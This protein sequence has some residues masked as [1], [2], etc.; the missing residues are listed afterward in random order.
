MKVIFCKPELTMQNNSNADDF[1][2]SCSEILNMYVTDKLYI[3]STFQVDQL[4]A[5][6]ADANDIFVFFNV[7]NGKYQDKFLRLIKKYHSAQSRIWAIAMEK[8]QECRR[9]P[10]PVSDK[11][12]FDVSCRNENRNPM[13]NNMRAIAQIFA[14]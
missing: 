12:S 3:S 1:F 10:D 9:P 5:S 14:R 7:E 4:L 13:K 6:D 8:N 2:K 11:Q